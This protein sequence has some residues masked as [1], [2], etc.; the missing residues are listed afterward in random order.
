MNDK[1]PEQRASKWWTF[2]N[3]VNLELKLLISVFYCRFWIRYAHANVISTEEQLETSDLHSATRKDQVDIMDMN[4]NH[5]IRYSTATN[6]SIITPIKTIQQICSANKAG[7]RFN[8][9]CSC[10][11]TMMVNTSMSMFLSQ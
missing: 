5:I 4:N 11:T 7:V 1:Q 2:E 10:G 9:S 8:R 3:S 6:H